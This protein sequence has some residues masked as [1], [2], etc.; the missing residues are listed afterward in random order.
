[1]QVA[2]DKPINIFLDCGLEGRVL[3]VKEF[4]RRLLEGSW[5]RFIY[6]SLKVKQRMNK[7]M[8][9]QSLMRN[10]S[11]IDTEKPFRPHQRLRRKVRLRLQ[12]GSFA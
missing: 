10:V 11:H 3:D 8:K 1:M 12:F 5:K 7:N 9:L 4:A 2:E 6:N